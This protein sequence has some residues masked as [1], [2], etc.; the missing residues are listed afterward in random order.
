MQKREGGTGW[1]GDD[2][3]PEGLLHATRCKSVR[4]LAWR[5]PPAKPGNARGGGGRQQSRKIRLAWLGVGGLHFM[6]RPQVGV[7]ARVKGLSP[8]GESRLVSLVRCLPIKHAEAGEF[9]PTLCKRGSVPF[10]SYLTHEEQ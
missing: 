1:V 6:P 4:G 5:D 9:N 2:P 10:S 7:L 3:F 8:K